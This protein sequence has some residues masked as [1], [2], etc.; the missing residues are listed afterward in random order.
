MPIRDIFLTAFILG[1]I[2]F[3]LRRPHVGIL[4]YVWISVMSPHR[5]TWSFAHD[6]NFAAIIAVVAL[7]SVLLNSKD[8]KPPPMNALMLTLALFL[9]WTSVTT[10][11]ALYPEASFLKWKTLMK[12]ALMVFL[13]PMVF[14]RKEH[15]RLLI[16][17]IVLSVAFYGTKGGTW[18]L[19]GGG[20]NRLWGPA[21]YIEDNNAL[22]V[23]IVMMIPLMRY[24]QLTTPHRYIRWGLTGM[25]LLCG[26]AVL[27]TYSRGALLAAGA[28]VAFLW[29]KGRHKLPVLLLVVI[30]I[31]FAFAAMP[32]QWHERMD[33][34]AN[35]ELDRSARMRLNSWETM[36]NIAKDRPLVGG[37]FEVAEPEVYARYS[38][39]P[40]FPPQVAHS[41]YFQAMGEHGFVGLGLFLLTYLLFWLYAGAVVRTSRARPELAWARDFGLMI[42]VTLVGFAV[43][44]AFLSLV[45]FDVPYYLIAAI[46]V[47]RL[48]VDQQLRVAASASAPASPSRPLPGMRPRQSP[49][50]GGS[51]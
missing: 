27:G 48:L 38:P 20:E 43:G 51:S 8:V 16:W 23:A 28:M 14:H 9:A 25:M 1:S 39:D 31:P 10:I 17:V 22:A 40:Q 44:G 2:P 33:K 30:A 45:N 41:I 26:V 36:F 11:L 21:G 19:I 49:R 35:L 4:M 46:V 13:I 37:G 50:P 3:I 5:L 47:V 12:T 29:W 32:G 15:L 42:Q 6:F 7:V 18:V 34:L 24:L